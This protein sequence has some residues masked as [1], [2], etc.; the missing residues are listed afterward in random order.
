LKE[1]VEVEN[2]EID[3]VVNEGYNEFLIE[4]FDNIWYYQ[5]PQFQIGGYDW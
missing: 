4:N 3:N 2:D 5:S 1:L